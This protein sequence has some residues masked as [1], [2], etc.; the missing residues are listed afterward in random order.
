MFLLFCIIVFITSLLTY[1]KQAKR[2]CLR[3]LSISLLW[4]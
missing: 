4:S 3:S 2:N 1:W